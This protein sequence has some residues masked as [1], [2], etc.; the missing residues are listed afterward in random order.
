MGRVARQ[1]ARPSKASKGS[2][3]ANGSKRSKRTKGSIRTQRATGA[4]TPD[5][6]SLAG[7]TLDRA[8]ALGAD[9]AEAFA[10]REAGWSVDVEGGRVAFAER[11]EDAGVGV[12]LSR[13]G[14]LGF[15]FFSDEAD[16]DAALRE[17]LGT[18]GKL[19]RKE[20][21]FPGRRA[22]PVVA[23]THDRRVASWG[24][25]EG[26]SHARAL[27]GGAKEA[28]RGVLVAGGG[29]AWSESEVAI[30]NSEGVRGAWRGT[31]A[32]ASLH[33][34]LRDG[35]TSTG[36]EYAVSRRADVDHAAVGREA[37]RLAKASRRPKKAPEGALAV[38][39]R[40]TALEGLLE[41][42][43]LGALSG[44]AARSGRSVYAE[45]LGERVMPAGVSL[46]E[47]GRLAGGPNSAPFDDEGVPSRRVP[48]VDG[49]VL[50]A[51]LDDVAGGLAAKGKSTSSAMR[52][53][54]MD[55]ER[56]WR[57]PPRASGRNIVL[58]GRGKPLEALVADVRSGL[59]V[60]DALGAHTANPASGDFSVNASVVFAIEDGEV[61]HACRPVMVAGNLP[62]AFADVRL[63]D[64]RR[65]LSGAFTP[66][67]FLV[68]SVR[69]D[70]IRVAAG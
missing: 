19:P 57:S 62:R 32:G 34:V 68:P 8:L 36:F 12:R 23:G 26:V 63:G 64:D 6:V 9:A 54:R 24:A 40:P 2:K 10:F 25:E 18:L 1:V 37:A 15:G 20:F 27:I 60:H 56:S 13:G 31:Q 55:S 21:T 14:R 59:V 51:Y 47:D 17:A 38:V 33:A 49:G 35:A 11:G 52:A 42:L 41:T 5:L 48:L 39:F 16:L 28:A 67:A 22:M 3:G 30:A 61:V 29:V 7:R 65:A 45:R 50:R 46:V 53:D 4:A 58:A 43:V 70:G 69:L 44:D 66:A